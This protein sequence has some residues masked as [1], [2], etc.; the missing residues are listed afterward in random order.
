MAVTQALAAYVKDMRYEDIPEKAIDL[1]K[2]AFSDYVAV[3]IA[4]RDEEGPRILKEFIVEQGGIPECSVP[5]YNLKTTAAYA[6]MLMGTMGH[7]LDYDD[8]GYT[9]RGH[10]S[11]V[12]AP[13]IW[14]LGDKYD[15]TGRKALE[16]FLVGFEAGALIGKYTM[17]AKPY[18]NSW[19][20]TKQVG[21]LCAAVT[22]GKILDLTVDQI[23]VALGIASSMSGGLKQNFGT[24]TK[25]FH[26]GIAVHDGVIAALLAQKGFTADLNILEAEF[27]LR[28]AF[29]SGDPPTEEAIIEMMEKKWWDILSGGG[30]ALKKSPAC[31]LGHH[32]IDAVIDLAVKEDINP[33]DVE[34]LTIDAPEYVIRGLFY[35][36]PQTGLEGKFSME[37]FAAVALADRKAGLAQFT[38]EKVQALKPLMKRVTAVTLEKETKLT[39]ARENHATAIFKLKD[40]RELRNT[41]RNPRGHP[42]NPLTW[43]EFSAKYAE[44]VGLHFCDEDVKKSEKLLR[45]LED[46]AHFKDIAAILAK[47]NK[48]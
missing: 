21:V 13:V 18:A 33:E 2:M 1:A 24:M 48:K 28:S 31:Y 17:A 22:A 47:D 15:I 4:G 37:F 38:T 3:T 45:N 30:L 25:S 40:G 34:S 8:V 29:Q 42:E 7:V 44:C 14:A 35:H 46:V 23:R 5:G 43:E 27:G 10:P 19:H 9:M 20:A 6:A 39:T 11:V 36:D 32:G 12:I 16:A 41:V 26:A